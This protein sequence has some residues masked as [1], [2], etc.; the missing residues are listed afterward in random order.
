MDFTEPPDADG[1]FL[2]IDSIVADLAK[3]MGEKMAATLNEMM[4]DLM[5]S[6]AVPFKQIDAAHSII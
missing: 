6:E 4:K 2:S 5:G 3:Q 1:D